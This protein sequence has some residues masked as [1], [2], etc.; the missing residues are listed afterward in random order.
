MKINRRALPSFA[1][2]AAAAGHRS[3]SRDTERQ[4]RERRESPVRSPSGSTRVR[5]PVAKLVCEDASERQAQDRHLRRRR[6]RRDDD[7]DEDPA[8]EPHRPRLAGRHLQRAGERPGLD[9]SE[10]VR[11]RD[12]PQGRLPDEP[13]QELAD[14]VDRAVHG[15]RAAGLPPGQ[16]R[17]GGALRQQ[18]ADDP[19]RLRG[20]DDVAGVG[21]ARPRRSR[22]S[23]PATSSAT[24]ATRTAP[25]STSGPTS[26][27]SRRWSRRTP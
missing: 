26:A 16:P 6:E 2:L 8:V 3:I 9:G 25:G 1:L 22:R 20:P 11:L 18:E 24:S 19:V 13:P 27:R 12:E 7:A 4:W 5:L 14:A 23:T 10:A 15:Q 21:G 17:P